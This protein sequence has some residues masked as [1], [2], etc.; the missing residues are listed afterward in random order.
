MSNKSLAGSV[1]RAEVMVCVVH[2]LSRLRVR[3]Q[4]SGSQVEDAVLHRR[5]AR[6][7]SPSSICCYLAVG[8]LGVGPAR[9]PV[10]YVQYG[11]Y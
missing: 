3:R 6:R 4:R 11:H 9:V 1:F 10:C 8:R 5:V 2:R 7:I